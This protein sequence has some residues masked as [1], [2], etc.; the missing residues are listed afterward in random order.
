MFVYYQNVRGLR[1]KTQQLY[2]QT[3]DLHY[4]IVCLTET[5]LNSSVLNGELFNANYTVYRR[6]RESCASLKSDGGGVLLAIRNNFLSSALPEYQ[7]DAEDLWISVNFPNERFLI[8]VVYLPPGDDA[9]YQCF[10]S[11]LSSVADRANTDNFLILGDFNRPN[12]TWI[13]KGNTLEPLSYD[14][15]SIDFI[16]TC[17]SHSVT[18]TNR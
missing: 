15:K 6:D 18:I 10:V 13:R 5:Y 8:C 1:T 17:S 14:N 16:D 7:S 3:L 2:T 9:A 4:D 12:I 11:N